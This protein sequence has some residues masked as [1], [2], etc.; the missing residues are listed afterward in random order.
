MALRIEKA[1]YVSMDTLLRMQ[2]SDDIAPT[3]RNKITI[4]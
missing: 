1:F 3:W 4:G 2:N